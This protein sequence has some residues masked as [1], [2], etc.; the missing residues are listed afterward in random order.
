MKGA[1]LLDAGRV[2]GVDQVAEPLDF[3]PRCGRDRDRGG[4]ASFGPAEINAYAWIRTW[5]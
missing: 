3:A 2:I 5:R 1:W 4:C